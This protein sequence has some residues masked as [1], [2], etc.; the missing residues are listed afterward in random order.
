MGVCAAFTCG[1]ETLGAAMGKTGSAGAGRISGGADGIGH[2]RAI[3]QSGMACMLMVM[4]HCLPVQQQN[5][6]PPLAVTRLSTGASSKAAIR[7]CRDPRMRAEAGPSPD[8]YSLRCHACWPV[9][10]FLG[11]GEA[12][13]HPGFR[14]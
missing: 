13:A 6:K 8:L 1:T 4:G 3:W 5:G 14:Q 9:T 7:M 10:L 2:M 12:I 11:Q